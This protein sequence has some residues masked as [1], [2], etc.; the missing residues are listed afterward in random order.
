MSTHMGWSWRILGGGAAAIV[1]MGGGIGVGVALTGGAAAATANTT[2]AHP[3]VKHPCAAKATRQAAAKC[4]RVPVAQRLLGHT[5]HAQLTVKTKT[6]YSTVAFERGTIASVSGSTLT[7]KAADG[8]TWTW[9]L[10]KGSVLRENGGK[11][12]ASKLAAGEKILAV[13]PVA[14][15]NNY[16]KM[17]RVQ[18]AG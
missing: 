8:T 18:P 16:V 17:A 7:V 11:L 9:H 5:L 3:T 15:G 4:L 13:G 1:L 14:H 2:A 12:A 10:L 6:G